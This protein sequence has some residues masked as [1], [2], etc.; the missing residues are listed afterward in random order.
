MNWSH[1]INRNIGRRPIHKLI[2][3]TAVELVQNEQFYSLLSNDLSAVASPWESYP[4]GANIF[5]LLPEEPGL[6]MF[7]WKPSALRFRTDSN[8][9]YFNKV[10]YLGK[11]SVSLKDRFRNEYRRIIEAASPEL[12]WD[13]AGVDSREMRLRRIFSLTPIDIWF[14]RVAVNNV[15]LIDNLETRLITLINPPGN[16][17]R[18]LKPLGTPQP[19]WSA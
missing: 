18:K 3:T 10:L 9:L 8:T 2:E 7:V 17:Q 12:F 13:D 11:A 5:Q 16:I 15:N 19:I 4:L 6:Y 1:T 14:C